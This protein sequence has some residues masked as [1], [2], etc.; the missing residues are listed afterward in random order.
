VP[1]LLARAI[2]K[3]KGIKGDT[4]KKKRLDK[5]ELLN[6]RICKLG[7][8]ILPGKHKAPSSNPNTIK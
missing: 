3:E 4:C 2:R 8:G 5:V 1:E 7:L 6:Q